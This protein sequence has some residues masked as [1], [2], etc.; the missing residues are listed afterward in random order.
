VQLFRLGFEVDARRPFN[1]MGQDHG[2]MS[3]LRAALVPVALLS[4]TICDR[5]IFDLAT[6]SARGQENLTNANYAD[7]ITA[8]RNLDIPYLKRAAT[9]EEQRKYAD[10]LELLTKRQSD[11]AQVVLLDLVKS[12]VDGSI[13]NESK[14]L[15]E[16][17]YLAESKWAD[18]LKIHPLPENGTDVYFSHAKAWSAGSP[19]EYQVGVKGITVPLEFTRNGQPL[20]QV[21]VNGKSYRFIVDTGAQF[22]TISKKVADACGVRA[23]PIEGVDFKSMFSAPGVIS[24]IT[25]G[26]VQM[27]NVPVLIV[28]SKNLDIKFAGLFTTMKIDG[29]IGWPQLKH[30]RLEVDTARNTLTISKSRQLSTED[31]HFFFYLRPL[32]KATALDG[33]PLFFWFD[34]GADH[35]SLFPRGAAKVNKPVTRQGITVG[36]MAAPMGGTSIQRRGVITN[37]HLSISG[38]AANFGKIAVEQVSNPFFDGCMGMDIGNSNKLVIDFPAGELEIR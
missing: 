17:V 9:N 27:R 11:S 33:T 36:S 38:K 8:S 16:T 28:A 30:L 19:T 37:L 12:A 34:T 4:W 3:K 21:M 23:I 32:V 24:T 22:S 5:S 35:T 1:N 20:V 14:L 10:V 2:R 29:I 7:F 25:I 15:L 31:S 13:R 18:L 26:E 6:C